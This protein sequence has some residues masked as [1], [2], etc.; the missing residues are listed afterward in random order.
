MNQDNRREG[1]DRSG[2]ANQDTDEAQARGG[3]AGG[4]RSEADDQGLRLK[5]ET[6]PA[7]PDALEAE[8]D[9]VEAHTKATMPPGEG[10]DPKRNTM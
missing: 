10:Q 4:G 1:T 8:A 2:K 6:T 3:Q 7:N 5:P 9:D